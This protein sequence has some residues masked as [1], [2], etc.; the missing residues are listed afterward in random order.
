MSQAGSGGNLFEGVVEQVDKAVSCVGTFCA[1][2]EDMDRIEIVDGQR[3]Q[4]I[5]AAHRSPEP[6][7]A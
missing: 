4:G 6:P 7:F 5:K 3:R 1:F 2:K